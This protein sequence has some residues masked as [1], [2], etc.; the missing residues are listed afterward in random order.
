[1]ALSSL[2][3]A[4][5]RTSMARMLVDAGL[6][7]WGNDQLDAG[8]R[9]ALAEY[10]QARPR[11]LWWA[12]TAPF[13]GTTR[14]VELAW[15]AAYRGA[16]V[17][18]V[19]APY[20]ASA[21]W[22]RGLNGAHPVR[23][24]VF[25]S[26][27]EAPGVPTIELEEPIEVAIATAKFLVQFELPRYELKDL[28][29]AAATNFPAH[30]DQPLLLGACGHACSMRAVDQSDVTTG[31]NVTSVGGSAGET[32]SLGGTQTYAAASGIPGNYA[33]LGAI[34]LKQFR[35]A[36]APPRVARSRRFQISC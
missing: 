13:D 2:D 17:R 16:K 22:P 18:A 26:G 1:M 12:G 27:V 33:A 21:Q 4:A 5:A 15:L 29:S 7:L 36:I 11:V 30:A 6:A 35:E 8:L 25:T 9:L 31:G 20:D 3:L 14:F 23:F 10:G 28:D 32:A 34:W 19:W 24:N